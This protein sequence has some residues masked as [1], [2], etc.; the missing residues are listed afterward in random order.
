MRDVAS[1]ISMQWESSRGG[2]FVSTPYVAYVST[3]DAL[4]RPYTYDRQTISIDST[5]AK[6]TREQPDYS[7]AA[8][9]FFLDR[10]VAMDP[11]LGY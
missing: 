4:T 8:D 10:A 1:A 11:C 5:G 7:L 6:T 2:I 3:L 9:P